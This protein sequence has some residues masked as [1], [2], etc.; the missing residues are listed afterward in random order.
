VNERSNLCG[1]NVGVIFYTYI[2]SGCIVARVE[3]EKNLVGFIPIVPS[4]LVDFIQK[5]RPHWWILFNSTV[6]TGGF[7]VIVPSAL[8]DFLYSTVLTH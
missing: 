4:A 3:S 7:S 8:V 5:Y 1:N 2:A 6:R